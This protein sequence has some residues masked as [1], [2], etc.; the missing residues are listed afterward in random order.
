MKKIIFLITLIALVFTGYIQGQENS[1]SLMKVDYKSLV[2][3][4]DLSYD[5]P[6]TRSE[7]GMPV[8]NG[9]NAWMGNENLC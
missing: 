5:S 9:T 1:N 4:S 3:K 8:G 2:S 6:V 7:E